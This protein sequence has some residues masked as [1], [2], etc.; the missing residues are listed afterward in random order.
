MLTSVKQSRVGNDVVVTLAS[1]TVFQ[2]DILTIAS[3]IPSSVINQVEKNPDTIAIQLNTAT[4]FPPWVSALPTPVLNPLETLLA[5]PINADNDLNKHISA[6]ATQ[7]SI[8]SIVNVLATAIPTKYQAALNSY[9]GDFIEE[10]VT[11]TTV[12]GWASDIPGPVQSSV[13]AVINQGLSIIASDFEATGLVTIKPINT[14]IAASSRRFPRPT[15]TVS[16]KPVFPILPTGIRPSTCPTCPTCTP[17]TV[18]VTVT[19]GQFSS[20]SKSSVSSSPSN[21]R[22]SSGSARSS[23]NGVFTASTKPTV[24]STGLPTSPTVAPPAPPGVFP[25]V[26]QSQVT[27]SSILGFT[28][29]NKST[30]SPIAFT[31]AAGPMKAAAAGVAALIA[32]VV[33]LMNV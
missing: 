11:A 3:A 15:T 13:G 9:P 1:N 27:A 31:G 19:G 30:G 2:N 24:A 14:P 29:T 26:V 32:G 5:K 22:V 23:G 20:P 10:L 33:I 12:P 6:L 21:S 8:S 28:G 18:Y 16:G 25:S 7:P 4:N 17:T